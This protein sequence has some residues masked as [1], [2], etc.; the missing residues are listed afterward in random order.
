MKAGKLEGSRQ[1]THGAVSPNWC[2]QEPNR[3][4]ARRWAGD[5]GYPVPVQ[6]PFCRF[7]PENLI[8][9]QWV[10]AVRWDNQC[11]RSD[12]DLGAEEGTH[13]QAGHT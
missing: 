2:T 5:S 13:L 10:C 6:T 8:A 4:P 9:V 3:P 7:F 12:L 1:L 11:S